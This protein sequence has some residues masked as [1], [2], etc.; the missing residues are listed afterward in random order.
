MGYSL[1]VV[2]DFR[3][4]NRFLGTGPVSAISQTSMYQFVLV[5]RHMVYRYGPVFWLGRK[6]GT[7]GGDGGGTKEEERGRNNE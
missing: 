6:R 2:K 5:Y 3:M 7:I 1:V 4:R